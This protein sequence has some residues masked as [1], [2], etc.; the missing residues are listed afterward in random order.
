[1]VRIGCPE[2]LSRLQTSMIESVRILGLARRARGFI[3]VYRAVSSSIKRPVQAPA[4][5]IAR[6]LR[7]DDQAARMAKLVDAP[8]LGPDASNGVGVRVPFLAPSSSIT[9]QYQHHEKS[10]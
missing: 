8:G 7:R 2:R 5:Q 10:H 6:P 3:A 9:Q 4:K 1:M